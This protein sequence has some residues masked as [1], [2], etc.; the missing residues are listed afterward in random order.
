MCS[1]W[2][3]LI[4]NGHY[5]TQRMCDELEL[6]KPNPFHVSFSKSFLTLWVC[7]IFTIAICIE[8]L[9]MEIPFGLEC[10]RW[11]ILYAL[12]DLRN[13]TVFEVLEVAQNTALA[14]IASCPLCQNWN[15]VFHAFHRF[16]YIWFKLFMSFLALPCHSIRQPSLSFIGH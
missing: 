4:V 16:F 1:N 7:A 11:Y 13:F 15:F 5:K 12:W 8:M 2:L 6:I 10:Q 3:E 14:F 9:N